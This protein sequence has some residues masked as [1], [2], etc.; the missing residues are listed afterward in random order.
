ME[1]FSFTVAGPY[2]RCHYEIIIGF[3]GQRLVLTDIDTQ[4]HRYTSNNHQFR[5]GGYHR[6]GGRCRHFSADSFSRWLM[7]AGEDGETGLS[8]PLFY[9]MGKEERK[10]FWNGLIGAGL[11]CDR[12]QSEHYA[13]HHGCQAATSMRL[14]KAMSARLDKFKHSMVWS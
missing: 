6:P 3:E 14:S 10:D 7:T 1:N 2:P 11:H 8:T 12:R 13:T 4:Y 9:P 5:I